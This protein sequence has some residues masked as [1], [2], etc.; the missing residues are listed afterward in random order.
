MDRETNLGELKE[1]VR[2]FC[3]EREWD[4]F[5]GPKDIAI[6]VITEAAELLEPFR[7]LSAEQQRALL[8]DPDKR[9]AI[10]EELA[11]VLFFVLR[12]AQRFDVDL[13]EAFAAK[14]AKNAAKYPVEKARGRNQ[15]YTE[16]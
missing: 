6:G 11:D 10:E 3:E 8:L 15:K 12:F 9:Q 5:H 13:A 14:M 16:L 2:R 7:F 1:A 4:P